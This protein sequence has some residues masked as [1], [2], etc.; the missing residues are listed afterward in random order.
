MRLVLLRLGGSIRLLHFH[1][2]F[3]DLPPA[4]AAKDLKPAKHF[5]DYRAA[6]R[7]RDV[8]SGF[9]C[10]K[11]KTNGGFLCVGLY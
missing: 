1:P 8:D 4:R 10:N 9:G 5:S 7:Q 2:R 11:A 3:A 6:V